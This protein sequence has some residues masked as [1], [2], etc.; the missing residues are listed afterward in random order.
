MVKQITVLPGKLLLDG[1]ELA[2]FRMG[3]SNHSKWLVKP[4]VI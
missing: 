2:D 4:F 1:Y 3:S